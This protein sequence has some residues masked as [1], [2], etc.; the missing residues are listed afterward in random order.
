MM[1]TQ[2]PFLRPIQP[3]GSEDRERIPPT[4]ADELLIRE[5]QARGE[6]KVFAP[7]EEEKIG[8]YLTFIFSLTEA[9]QAISSKGPLSLKGAPQ[10]DPL[11]LPLR[12]LYKHLKELTDI[13]QS[14]NPAYSSILAS[15]WNE[16]LTAA[17]QST[18]VE[19]LSLIQDIQSYT[20]G[21]KYSLGYYLSEYAG[22]SWSPLPYIE[23]L[24]KLHQDYMKDPKQS[25]L[26]KWL[27]LLET[28]V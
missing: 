13:N 5:E 22:R 20:K 2:D 24:E 19:V 4:I 7:K 27:N 11:I 18:S 25:H 26:Q 6:I 28:L 14:K 17:R 3:I 10:S 15:L 9:L 21:T 1:S 23:L 12:R 16:V 8:A